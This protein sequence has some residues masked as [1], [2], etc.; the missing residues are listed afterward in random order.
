MTDKLMP[1]AMLVDLAKKVAMAHMERRKNPNY[2]IQMSNNETASFESLDAVLKAQFKLLVGTDLYTYEQNK[3]LLFQIM[4]EVVDHVLPA[5]V[6]QEARRFAEVRTFAQGTK[7][8]FRVAT[9]HGRAKGFISKAASASNYNIFRLDNANIE[10][11]TFAYGGAVNIQIEQFLDGTA[12]FTELLN[13]VIT[14]IEGAIYREARIALEQ[15]AAR[16][17]NA[18]A[19]DDAVN[20]NDPIVGAN[21]VIVPGYNNGAMEMLLSTIGSYSNTSQAQILATPR[22]ARNILNNNA[23]LISDQD[24]MDHREH[25]YVGKIAGAS[26]VALPNAVTDENNNRRVFQDRYAYVFPV[27]PV[28][29][30]DQQVVKIAL[31]GSTMFQEIPG[32]SADWSRTVQVYKKMG[33]A[34]ATSIPHLGVYEDL[35]IP[36]IRRDR[37][38]SL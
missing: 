4:T 2:R 33:V 24:R 21:K 1:K 16:H 25:G 12:D 23:N 8:M 28:N 36:L 26:I 31:E 3:T 14:E 27:N 9:G 38:N 18:V 13:I 22:F 10:V 19:F 37:I 7:P 5:A 20:P 32:Q 6:I 29:G 34:I 35:S 15:L 30:A 11:P 17:R